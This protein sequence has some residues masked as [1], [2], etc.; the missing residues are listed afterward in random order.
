VNVSSA[1]HVIIYQGWVALHFACGGGRTDMAL[2]LVSYGA[3]PMITNEVW[4][5]SCVFSLYYHKD[6]GTAGWEV[7]L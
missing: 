5:S 2:L 6:A 3:D 4:S 7:R 1:Y